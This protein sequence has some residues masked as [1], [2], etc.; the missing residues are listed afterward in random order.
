MPPPLYPNKKSIAI[1]SI[2]LLLE[3]MALCSIGCGG[4]SADGH[5]PTPAGT[6]VPVDVYSNGTLVSPADVAQWAA[7]LN[8]Q[9]A[10]DISP[11][12]GVNATFTVVSAWDHA[13]KTLVVEDHYDGPAVPVSEQN[14][15]GYNDLATTAWVDV[16]QSQTQNGTPESTAGKETIEMV[17]Q[18]E[19]TGPVAP[20]AYPVA[21][22]NAT[23]PQVLHDFCLPAYF[24]GDGGL[25]DL[26]GVLSGPGE[27]AK[28]GVND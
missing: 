1:M 26:M 27:I 8:L 14:A 11:A 6:I 23:G 4:G 22:V 5:V 19:C 13:H 16:Y 3:G 17:L 20:Y 18:R 21:G 24:T 2:W 28:G 25:Y 10:R 7:D 12:W 15:Q 9:F